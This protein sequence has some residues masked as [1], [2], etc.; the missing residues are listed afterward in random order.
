MPTG[1][2]EFIAASGVLNTSALFN[3]SQVMADE[4]GITTLLRGLILHSTTIATLASQTS[5]TLT[6]GSADA[7]AYEGALI[8]VRD[9]T[10]AVQRCVGLIKTYDVTTK[11]VTLELD[12]GV[13]TMGV[14]DLVDI[15]P[16]GAKL[17]LNTAIPGSPTAD[18]INERVA[19][20]DAKLPSR[21]YLAGSAAATGETQTDTA[22]ALEAD[23]TL[24]KLD[25]IV[26]VTP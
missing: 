24:L 7:K 13:F 8:V 6:T 11:T 14:G 18:S 12:P 22:A 4:A 2:A 19:A 5:F 26:Q 16:S 9:A 21:A 23:P 25:S 20:I 3:T 17:S 10:T 15:L 1:A